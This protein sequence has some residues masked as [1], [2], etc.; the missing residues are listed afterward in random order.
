VFLLLASD[1]EQLRG[2]PK[3]TTHKLFKNQ[4]AV[5][6]TGIQAK[7]LLSYALQAKTLSHSHDS[8][9]LLKNALAVEKTVA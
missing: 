1:Q 4:I 5:Q 2:K 6:L 8:S 3:L 7:I 9:N